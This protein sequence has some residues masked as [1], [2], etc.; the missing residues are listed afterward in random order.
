MTGQEN[1]LGREAVQFPQRLLHLQAHLEFHAL[2]KFSQ[3]IPRDTVLPGGITPVQ[4]RESDHNSA[5]ENRQNQREEVA[6]LETLFGAHIKDLEQRPAQGEDQGQKQRAPNHQ[7][8]GKRKGIRLNTLGGSEAAENEPRRPGFFLNGQRCR[9]QIQANRSVS[10]LQIH[11][12][13]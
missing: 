9:L 4:S 1:R 6:H 8:V 12:I 11:N 5:D 10:Q 2:G 13:S 3:V 7:G